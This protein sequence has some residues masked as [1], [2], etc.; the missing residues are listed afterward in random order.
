[1]EGEVLM[2]MAWH[3]QRLVSRFRL[4][5]FGGGQGVVISLG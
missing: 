1:M 5:V 2:F 3:W 4:V